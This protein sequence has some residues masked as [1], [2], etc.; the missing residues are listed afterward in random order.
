MALWLLVINGIIGG[1]IFGVPAKAEQLAA[2]FSPW[3]FVLCAKLIAPI[4]LCIAQ[5]SSA[6][7]GTGGPMLYVQ[8]AFGPFAGFQVG[9]AFYIARLTAFAAN[10]NLLVIY[11]FVGS[12]QAWCSPANRKSCSATCHGNCVMDVGQANLVSSKTSRIHAQLPSKTAITVKSFNSCADQSNNKQMIL[13][14]MTSL[15]SWF[16]W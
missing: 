1:G 12:S 7:G 5:L 6:F 15:S 14:S 16:S 10:L 2:L 9:W 11:A 3:V 13:I 8:T 4:M